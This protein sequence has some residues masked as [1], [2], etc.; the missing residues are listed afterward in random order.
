MDCLEAYPGAGEAQDDFVHVSRP[1][2]SLTPRLARQIF[3]SLAVLCLGVAAAFSAL[4]YWL[5]L[6]FAGLEIGLLAWAFERVRAHAADY[7]SLVISGDTVRLEW[8]GEHGAGSR[9]FNRHWA[10]VELECRV[11]GRACKVWLCSHGRGSEVG[12]FLGDEERIALARTLKRR[13]AACGRGS[14][15][16]NSNDEAGDGG[17]R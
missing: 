12:Q 16:R 7:E 3:W 10:R 2:A 17:D 14:G 9:E 5:I 11:P 6:P 15:Y 1:R 13:M 8:R 4:G